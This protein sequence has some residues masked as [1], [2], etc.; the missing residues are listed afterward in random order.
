MPRDAEHVDE[1]PL[2]R[3]VADRLVGRTSLSFY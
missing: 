3:P 2:D 1:V